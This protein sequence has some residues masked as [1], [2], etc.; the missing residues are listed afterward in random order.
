[1]MSM[2]CGMIFPGVQQYMASLGMGMGMNCPMMPFP[3]VL[4]GSGLPTPAEA[5]HLAPRFPMACASAPDPSRPQASNQ[6]ADTVNSSGLQS[7]NLPRRP[8]IIPDP[9]QQYRV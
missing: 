9:Y 5:C 8:F 4:P 6:A 3:H 1:M 7:S 2:G